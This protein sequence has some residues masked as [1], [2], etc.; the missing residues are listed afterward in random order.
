MVE[1]AVRHGLSAAVLVEAW[2]ER[3]AIR[4]HVG[5]FSP[6]AAEVWAI[7]DVEQEYQIGLHCPET[8]RRMMA[9]GARPRDLPPR[10]EG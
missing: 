9:G 7:G 8:R 4:Q 10:N 3:A 6:A 5:G 2:G 1:L